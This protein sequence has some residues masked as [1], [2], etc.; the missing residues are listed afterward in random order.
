M[1]DE[2]RNIIVGVETPTYQLQAICKQH[3][4]FIMMY[5]YQ[6]LTIFSKKKFCMSSPMSV[7]DIPFVYDI[8]VIIKGVPHES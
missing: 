2:M 5:F 1:S 3:Q 8:I 6:L 4:S 7:S